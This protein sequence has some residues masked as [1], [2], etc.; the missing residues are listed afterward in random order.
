MSGD[1]TTRAGHGVVSFVP[2]GAARLVDFVD[3][4]EEVALVKREL[5]DGVVAIGVLEGTNDFLW[6]LDSIRRS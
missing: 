2:A 6:R 5:V 1:N 3:D 4:M